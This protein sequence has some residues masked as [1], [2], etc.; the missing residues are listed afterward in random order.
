LHGLGPAIRSGD[1]NVPLLER[2]EI[3][4][5]RE[6]TDQR[7]QLREL[8]RFSRTVLERTDRIHRIMHTAAASDKHAADLERRD[9][10]TRRKSQRA[11]IDMLLTNGPL[12]EGLSLADARDT[13]A[14]LANPDT[15]AFMTSE[16][17]W[18]P[19]RFEDWLRESLTLL[20][21]P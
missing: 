21:L 19:Q 6:Y 10:Q 9:R 1:T 20:L 2:P 4:R 11:Y 17:G 8:A 18:T 14:A 15:F 13:H 12:L 7:Q 5:I 3:A 16:C